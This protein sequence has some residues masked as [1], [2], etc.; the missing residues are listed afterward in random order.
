LSVTINNGDR[1]K[2]TITPLDEGDYRLVGFLR[3]VRDLGYTGQMGLQCWGIKVPAEEH[4]AR[5]MRRWRAIR[6]EVLGEG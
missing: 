4:L 3:T 5:S 1:A 6:R 2:H